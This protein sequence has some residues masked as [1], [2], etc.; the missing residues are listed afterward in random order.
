MRPIC[1]ILCFVFCVS[2]S[3]SNNIIKH[4]QHDAS[5]A[6]NNFVKL[7]LVESNYASAYMLLD[8]E[9]QKTVTVEKMADNIT[10]MHPK[11]RPATIQAIEYEPIPGQRAMN[12]YLLG[13][14]GTDK[15][16]YRIVMTGDAV[17][18]YKVGG[19]LRGTGPYPASNRKPL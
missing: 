12:I 15:F 7:G 1:Y 9:L 18:G 2:A 6:A 19:I 14:N 4:N 5:K 10:K 8:T 16:Y 3:C 17:T 11:D 13:S